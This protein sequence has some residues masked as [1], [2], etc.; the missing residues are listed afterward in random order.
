ME[1]LW[2]LQWTVL[3]VAIAWFITWFIQNIII[4]VTRDLNPAVLLQQSNIAPVRK[5][6]ETAVY[7][8]LSVPI[9]LPLT[10]GLNIA[11]G[12]KFR[13]GN[14]IDIWSRTLTKG[15]GKNQIGFIDGE[16]WPLEKVNY[17]AKQLHKFF[18]RTQVK[19]IG[20]V[21]SV[22]TSTGFVAA[23]AAF[24]ASVDGCIPQF[25]PCIPRK[26]MDLDVLV[27]QSWELVALLDS[28]EKWYKVVI[29]C[30]ELPSSRIGLSGRMVS[31]ASLFQETSG[32]DPEFHYSPVD[33]TDDGKELLRFTNSYFETTSFTHTCLV[34]SVA[35]FI[36]SFPVQFQLRE[37]DTLT[38]V[39]EM[40]EF[41]LS[42]QVWTKI[43]A[44]LLH[45]GSV[46]FICTDDLTKIDPKTSLLFVAANA[47]GINTMLTA[48]LR[49][50]NRLALSWALSL[51]SEG[52]FSTAAR[53]SDSFTKLRCVFL[54]NEVR[55][56][57]SVSLFPLE[58][59]K[60]QSNAVSRLTSHQM[61][62]LRALF[63]ARVIMELYS[64]YTI[65]GPF[66]QT[67]FYDYRVFPTAVDKKFTC[68]GSLSSSMEGKLVYTDVNPELKPANRQGMLLIR[69]FTIG[70]PLDQDRLN[71]TAKLAEKF[72]SGKGWMVMV[73]EYGLWGKD[74]CFYEY[75]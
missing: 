59:P 62:Q 5:E 3:S 26:K 75:K 16:K 33:D 53:I 44:V 55:D 15:H 35:S 8:N 47:S 74:G 19:S 36:K 17:M 14:F 46:N 51:L 68:Y 4:D 65:M 58:M 24:M 34:S 43:F 20:I 54:M 72:E 13:R 25:L 32:L 9:G 38:I 37:T 61:N 45:G 64:P 28:S 10:T 57:A 39:T 40:L 2:L 52:V 48:Y 18:I 6:K 67:N 7:R 73:G 70:K 23:T 21:A 27:I 71:K 50:S 63:G 1:L 66:A 69:G 30:E 12:Y 60:L 42:L 22:A 11:I 49:N 31:I 56:V 29:V 41:C